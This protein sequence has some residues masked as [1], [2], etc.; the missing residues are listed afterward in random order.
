[1]RGRNLERFGIYLQVWPIEL[2][3]RKDCGEKVKQIKNW[4][5]YGERFV[6]QRSMGHIKLRY[7]IDVLVFYF[8]N[9]RMNHLLQIAPWV[10][11]G[12]CWHLK[13]KRNI[14]SSKLCS[15]MLQCLLI[16]SKLAFPY[17]QKTHKLDCARNNFQLFIASE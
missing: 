2:A 15:I 4:E 5:E 3:D 16:F 10:T 8:L 1:M 17:Y 13:A 6:G 7:L 9:K 12:Q 14:F 11:V